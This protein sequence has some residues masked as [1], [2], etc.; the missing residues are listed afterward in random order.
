MSL[1]NF[2]PEVTLQF[3]QKLNLFDRINLCV[4]HT[5]LLPLCFDRSLNRKY[6]K[7]I[8]LNELRQLYEQSKTEKEKDYCFKS[9]VLDR[10]LIKNCN[11]V[12]HLYMDRRN[13]Q[14]LTNGKILRSLDGKFILEGGREKF[15]ACFIEQFM[16]L[17]ERAEGTLLLALVDVQTFEEMD[18]AKRCA[19]ILSSK[20]ERGQKVYCIISNKTY[21]RGLHC[22]GIQIKHFMKIHFTISYTSYAYYFSHF[23][24]YINK[25]NSL[26]N[27][28]ELIDK[29]ND[30]DNL[31][32]A[33]QRLGKV[34]SLV[35]AAE[36]PGFR[37]NIRCDNCL[38][39]RNSGVNNDQISIFMI[40]GESDC[41]GCELK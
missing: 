31:L 24:L 30:E 37:E 6:R 28:K 23:D 13:D 41:A 19:R 2:P 27:T 39:T 14:F 9:I 12:V 15:S 38:T 25:S 10:L 1:L 34:L 32:E 20:M 21:I 29:T 4:T 11:E 18:D 35:E 7:T 8:T 26:A 40:Y 33:K 16:S 22:C 36:L 5:R 3:I 17:L